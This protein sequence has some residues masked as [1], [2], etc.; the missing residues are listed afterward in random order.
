MCLEKGIG[1]EQ[2]L[3]EAAKYYKMAS[4]RNNYYGLE[5][6]ARCLDQ[7]IGIEQNKDE[8]LRYYNL[9]ADLGN[10]DALNASGLVAEEL[11]R[12]SAEGFRMSARQG[13]PDGAYN[14]GKCLECG[15]GIDRNLKE[16]ARWY[17]DAA[18]KG[19]IQGQISYGRCLENG[20][21]LRRNL[22]E[23]AKWYKKAMN[24][25]NREGLECYNRCEERIE[26][27]SS[28]SEVIMD[29]S[30]Y[31]QCEKLRKGNF[32]DLRLMEEMT[33]GQKFT[34]KFI[35]EIENFSLDQFM[36]GICE[37]VS[38]S[39]PSIVEIVG[40]SL[41]DSESRKV[42]I[43]M[44]FVSNRSVEDV[45][46]RSKKWDAWS[47]WTHKCI[48]RMIIELAFGMKYLHLK[49]VIHGDLRPGNLLIDDD[50]HLRIFGFDASLFK[51]YG[52][53]NWISNF[54]YLSPEAL[55][56]KELTK[57]SDVYGFGL[58]VYEL[59]LG[60]SVFPKGTPLLQFANMLRNKV[61]PDIPESVPT[62]ISELIKKC[63][64]DDAAL[65]PTF[66]E[67]CEV[68]ENVSFFAD[69]PLSVIQN[70]ISRIKKAE[71]EEHLKRQQSESGRVEQLDDDQSDKSR[72]QGR[73]S[74]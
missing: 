25:G 63:W 44:E 17:K 24:S 16:A 68:L 37:L 69:V 52:Y 64:D 70:C 40:Y 57:E 6:Y 3:A 18:D 11:A 13:N 27:N 51:S 67:I 14:Y 7:G 54:E 31:K 53:K 19:H 61:R 50:N 56:G 65:R 28:A 10:E 45:L 58:I 55:D 36:K 8:G 1:V 72:E 35:D 66:G 2:N 29:L 32:W 49:N 21:G 43:I 26:F 38:L 47:F 60:E 9:A 71:N 33:S 62:P 39:H 59:L 30:N 48:S 42:R 74:V 5:N 12:E 41:P 34:V 20:F 4:D 46:V 73:R 15:R 22:V 23:A